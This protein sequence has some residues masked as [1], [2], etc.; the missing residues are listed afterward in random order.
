[1]IKQ[2]INPLLFLFDNK[3][4]D[5]IAFG[6]IFSFF[7]K[8]LAY[9]ITF[10]IGILSAKYYGPSKIGELTIITT[11]VNI[12]IVFSVFG[13]TTLVLKMIPQNINFFSFKTIIKLYKKILLIICVFSCFTIIFLN[14]FS[15][16]L[17][18]K[19]FSDKGLLEFIVKSSFVIFFLSIANLNIAVIRALKKI[20]IHAL[21]EILPKGL[22]LILIVFFTWY[23]NTDN[24]LIYIFLATSFVIS[25]ISTIY[26]ITFFK[27]KSSKRKTNE[28]KNIKNF[29][30]KD[31][32]KQ[33]SPMFIIGS[34][35]LIMSQT[36][37]LMIG[38]LKST[39]ELGIYNI[40]FALSLLC[41]F[42]LNSVNVISAPKFSEIFYANRAN[43]LEQ[44]A[45]KSSFIAFI[46]TLPIALILIIFGKWILS[47]YGNDF[48]SGYYV[49]IMLVIG[50]L[51]NSLSGSVGYFL[52]MTGYQKQ[53][54]NI[55]LISALM[56]IFLNY[57]L[58]P[59][60]GI[61]GAALATLASTI[62]WNTIGT[63]YIKNKFGFY[64]SYIASLIS[65]K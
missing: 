16:Y 2:I 59:I 48:I 53:L 61:Y 15:D 26:I 6:T 47:F 19:L 18:V 1:M 41:S 55:L 44:V 32:I 54:Q 25:I 31:L 37:T 5:E 27:K 21:F 33:A 22:T 28:P 7:A 65:K 58:I 12:G 63:I 9:G 36:D 4:K 24:N 43:E 13:F 56:N 3:K 52:N 35:H 62:L 30:A 40:A 42:V 11:I 17:A 8:I 64:I 23:I 39:E 49:L 10:L 45:V 20:K 46:G 34:L 51:I 60:Y 29:Q 50:Q 14:L 57:I 38:S